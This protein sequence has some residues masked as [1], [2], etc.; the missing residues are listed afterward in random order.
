M[1]ANTFEVF[2]FRKFGEAQVP[3]FLKLERSAGSD[4]TEPGRLPALAEDSFLRLTKG[5]YGPLLNE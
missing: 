1:S 4:L 2:R 3:D 5:L